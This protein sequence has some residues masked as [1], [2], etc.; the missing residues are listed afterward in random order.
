MVESGGRDNI[1]WPGVVD[2][3]KNLQ[4]GKSCS[5]HRLTFKRKHS[6]TQIDVGFKNMR[7]ICNESR[8]RII[9]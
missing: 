5:Y 4:G 2:G 1:Q 8:P 9:R 3:I 7:Y 6:R